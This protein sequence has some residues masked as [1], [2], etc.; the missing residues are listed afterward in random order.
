MRVFYRWYMTY[1]KP[2]DDIWKGSS[3]RGI[4]SR[5]CVMWL[6]INISSAAINDS[7]H[8]RHYCLSTQYKYGTLEQRFQILFSWKRL[9]AT[10]YFTN[11]LF[12]LI[13]SPG[14]FPPPPPP[15]PPQFYQH[16][17]TFRENPWNLVDLWSGNFFGTHLGDLG[18]RSL[19]YRSGTQYTLSPR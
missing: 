6:F 14:P 15:P 16:F 3:L 1:M 5:R 13:K 17:L 18:S 7:L 12:L 11:T 19:S 10:A 9:V 8:R 2:F 4:V